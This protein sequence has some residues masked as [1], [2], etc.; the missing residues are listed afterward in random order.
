[1]PLIQRSVLEKSKSSVIYLVLFIGLV[2]ALIGVYKGGVH[3]SEL[4]AE[5]VF[6]PDL[7]GAIFLSLM[8]MAAA[9]CASL[10]FAYTFGLLAARTSMGER[11]ILPVL[12]ILQ[13]AL[14]VIEHREVAIDDRI[15]ER[16][17][18][19]GRAM[20]QQRRLMLAPRAY[21]L[22]AFFHTAAH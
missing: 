1:M 15:H 21:V 13:S 11:F 14:D 12:D 8:R 9:Y 17:Q 2:F 6:L 4:K 18:N 10:V 7:P 16:I 5:T 19:I 22:K 20:A 3:L